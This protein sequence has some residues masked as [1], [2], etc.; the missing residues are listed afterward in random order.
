MAVPLGR[1][2]AVGD[3]GTVDLYDEIT[4]I[5]DRGLWFIEAHIQRYDGGLSDGGADPE[6]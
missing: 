2:D 1:A 3:P 6:S 5:A 4:H